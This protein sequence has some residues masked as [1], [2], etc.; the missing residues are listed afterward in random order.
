[1]EPV[2]CR[3]CGTNECA[4]FWVICGACAAKNAQYEESIDEFRRDARFYTP[5]HRRRDTGLCS[6]ENKGRKSRKIEDYTRDDIPARG[7]WNTRLDY[8]GGN[9]VDE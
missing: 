3:Q 6:K 7:E 4:E 2:I 9:Y 8:H 1:M 5:Y